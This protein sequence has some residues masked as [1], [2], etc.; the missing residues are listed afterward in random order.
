VSIESS[1]SIKELF[2]TDFTGKIL[3]KM[4]ASNKRIWTMDL[5]AYP[6]GTYL[7]KYFTED[8]GWGT[9]KVVLIH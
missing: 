2:I 1:G 7:V 5:S 9:E 4:P 8:K 6:S 3:M